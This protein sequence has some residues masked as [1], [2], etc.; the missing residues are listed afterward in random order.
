[1]EKLDIASKI[2][3]LGSD[4]IVNLSGTGGSG[5]TTVARRFIEEFGGEPLWRVVPES[6][7]KKAF[8]IGYDVG[9]LWIP[10]S[11]ETECGGC[12]TINW[13]GAANYLEDQVRLVTENGHH[14]LMEGYVQTKGMKRWGA[15]PGIVWAFLDTPLEVCK[16]R[17]LARNGGKE[18]KEDW[19]NLKR[20]FYYHLRMQE[21]C[22]KEG[23]RKVIINYERAFEQVADLLREGGWNGDRLRGAVADSKVSTVRS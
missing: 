8:V 16:E 19:K 14:V 12:D 1:M 5:K 11:Y 21:R 4:M 22:D 20:S 18:G 17:I 3:T 23:Q 10:G 9:Q 15:F 7:K 2:A 13:K 6:G